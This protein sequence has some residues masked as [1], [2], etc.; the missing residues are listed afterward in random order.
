MSN[1]NEPYRGVS[2]P[3]RDADIH[4]E[5]A[6]EPPAAFTPLTDREFMVLDWL[7]EGKTNWE[8]AAILGISE[9]TVKFHVA[10]IRS[11]LSASSRS[12][13]VALAYSHNLIKR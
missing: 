7:K 12:H 11:K 6:N 1:S 10:N 8:I 3:P 4:V 13:A 2:F 9:R 5:M